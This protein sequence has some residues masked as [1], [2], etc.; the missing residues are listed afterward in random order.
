MITTV[1]ESGIEGLA[2]PSASESGDTVVVVMPLLYT[3]TSAGFERLAICCFN[4]RCNRY[5]HHDCAIDK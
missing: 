1:S 5:H 3:E 4:N 2:A